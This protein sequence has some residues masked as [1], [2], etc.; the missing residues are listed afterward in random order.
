MTT[1][2]S[3]PRRPVGPFGKSTT[4]QGNLLPTV[5][6]RLRT[7]FTLIVEV[8]S[9]PDGNIWAVLLASARGGVAPYFAR[10]SYA[11]CAALTELASVLKVNFLPSDDRSS[12]PQ[13][14]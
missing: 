9:R 6:P 7:W 11:H 12:P 3:K 1:K 5:L 4:S 14:R 8:A 2:P 13:V 10:R